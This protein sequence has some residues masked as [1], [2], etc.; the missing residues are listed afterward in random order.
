[1]LWTP[2]NREKDN[3]LQELARSRYGTD[4]PPFLTT[5]HF[6]GRVYV[7]F[8]EDPHEI[9]NWKCK[10]MFL[11]R[12]TPRRDPL[13]D[14]IMAGACQRETEFPHLKDYI[15]AAEDGWQDVG[16]QRLNW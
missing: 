12:K 6:N 4:R 1:M 8:E 13:K 15:V 3:N 14:C 7:Q 10:R 9:D 5:I 11:C 2:Q 16:P